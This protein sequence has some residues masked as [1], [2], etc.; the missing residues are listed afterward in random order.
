M[1]LLLAHECA[2]QRRN[3]RAAHGVTLHTP[4]AA[5]TEGVFFDTR[6]RNVN[7]KAVSGRQMKSH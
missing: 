6:C 1:A 5:A 7:A 2:R 3:G 4:C